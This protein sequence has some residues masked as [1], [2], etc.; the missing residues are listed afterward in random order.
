MQNKVEYNDA[1]DRTED[2]DVATCDDKFYYS[3]SRDRGLFKGAMD[4]ETWHWAESHGCREV[5]EYGELTFVL[6]D[7]T[8]H[9]RSSHMPDQPFAELDPE[10]CKV[11]ENFD[12]WTSEGNLLNFASKEEESKEGDREKGFRY[13]RAT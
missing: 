7:G 3:F 1:T 6:I 8:V 13:L 12:P 4:P 2:D 10:T 5:D 9:V 11:K